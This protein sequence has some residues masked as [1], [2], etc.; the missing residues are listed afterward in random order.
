MNVCQDLFERIE[1]D[2]NSFKREITGDESWIFEY[3]PEAKRR[4]VQNGTRA[5]HRARRKQ[6]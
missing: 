4:K 1:S 6:E 2:E 5:A 3:D